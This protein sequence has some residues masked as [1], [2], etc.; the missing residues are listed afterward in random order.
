M[1]NNLTTRSMSRSV[2]ASTK[3]LQ[4][5]TLPHAFDLS[6]GLPSVPPLR[7]PISVT[8]SAR[9]TAG[10][11]A[12]WRA[13]RARLAIGV[14]IL[15][16]APALAAEI[17][18]LSPQMWG[19][20]RAVEPATI[21]LKP[22]A[23]PQAPAALSLKECIALAFRHNA[24]FR[25]AQERLTSSRRGLWVADQRL[26]YT[27]TA[28]GQRERQPGETAGT[29][30]SS[31]VAARWE[32]AGGGALQAGLGTGTQGTF[33]DLFSQQPALSLSYDQPLM[34]G[35]GLA[36]STAERIRSAGTAL[37]AQELSFY[38][39]R[40]GLAQSVI[41][42]YFAVL[43]ARG[44][45]DI[46]QRAVERGKGL[47]DIN[48]AKFSGEGLKKPG[49]EWISQVAE[50]DVDQARL[51]WERSKQSLIS[52]QQAYRDAMDGLL[53]DMG[54]VPGA[55]PE[56]TTAI[57][58]SPKDYDEAALI[59]TALANSTELGRLEL[60]RQDSDAALRIAR[61][62]RRPDV[63]ASVGVTDLGET[64]GGTT[65]STGWFSGVR[66]EVPLRERRRY[67]NADR[68]GRALK[69][70]EQQVVAAR[71]RVAQEV[72]RQVR[73]AA[74]S[75]ARTDIGEQSVTLARK[76]REAAQGMYDEGL[77]DYLRVL[78]A[79][80]R[81]VEAERSL[82]QE[83]VQYFVTTVRIRRALGEDITQGLPD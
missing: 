82:L 58:Y 26:F 29:S 67:E 51:S 18:G 36:S 16:A 57:A 40:Q 45:V 56:L 28:Q 22:T 42:D 77:S 41:G 64:L 10:G 15:I 21:D 5:L 24:D 27:V 23:S 72:Q 19:R 35:A 12:D 7:R 44:E 63:I 83:Q 39:G 81:L 47:Y 78:D 34:R 76:N 20:V 75:R 62:E 25:Q 48:Y 65:V 68:A 49:E 61:S 31:D 73:A 33:G 1:Q 4:G 37:Q 14:L 71:D 50:I 17:A 79:E 60:S 2:V 70:L 74:S 30:L 9:L 3:E 46:A 43:L 80:D 32:Q 52:R 13:M 66:M 54:F 38:D 6:S 55:T 11:R 8:S 69:V 53:L 59:K